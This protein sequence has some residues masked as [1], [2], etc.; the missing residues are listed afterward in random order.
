MATPA[1][2]K[3]AN[4]AVSR[5]NACERPPG[6]PKCT[7]PDAFLERR[8]HDAQA[9]ERQPAGHGHEQRRREVVVTRRTQ[10]RQDEAAVHGGGGAVEAA[11]VALHERQQ[12]RRGRPR[13]R[14]AA[15]RWGRARRPRDGGRRSADARTP[16]R[17][18]RR[19]AASARPARVRTALAI[20]TVSGH[21]PARIATAR[22]ESTNAAVSCSARSATPVARASPAE[23]TSDR[24]AGAARGPR[25]HRVAETGHG[26]GRIRPRAVGREQRA[27]D[28]GHE[29]RER[30]LRAPP[31]GRHHR[32]H[33]QQQAEDQRLPRGR[34]RHGRHHEAGPSSEQA[35]RSRVSARSS[36]ARQRQHR[37]ERGIDAVIEP[38]AVQRGRIH[39]RGQ[40]RRPALE[41]R[42]RMVGMARCDARRESCSAPSGT[43]PGAASR[44]TRDARAPA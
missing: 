40:P 29:Q 43:G 16:A 26:H 19:A 3:S 37:R 36:S 13:A 9:A 41:P 33:D 8:D 42:G 10:R 17:S 25:V 32:R 7:R 31:L 11:Q 35:R 1:A 22:V 28:R 4:A 44:G 5:G 20:P 34:P 38:Q 27:D 24:R 18:S 15:P 14:P 2:P 6:W 21:T 30:P 39:A 23:S 12:A